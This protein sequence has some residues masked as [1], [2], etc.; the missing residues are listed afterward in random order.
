MKRLIASLTATIMLVGLLAACGGTSTTTPGATVTDPPPS[1]SESK[2]AGGE[3]TKPA[4][5]EGSESA[6]VVDPGGSDLKLVDEPVEVRIATQQATYFGEVSEL[7]FTKWYAEKTGV[8]VKWETVPQASVSETVSLMMA[9]PDSLPDAM[10][11]LD[12][13]TSDLVRYGSQ[14]IF[15]PLQDYIAEKGKYTKAAY[16][17]QYLKEKTAPDG[18]IYALPGVNACYHCMYAG[19]AYI[20]QTW[21][22]NLGLEYPNTTDEFYEVLKAFKEQDANNNGDPND[23]IPMFGASTGWNTKV[24]DH[25]MGAFVYNDHGRRLAL[26]DGKITFVANTEAWKQGL[27][28]I[29]K[30]FDEEFI[31]ATALTV[32]NDGYTAVGGDIN[33]IRVGVVTGATWWSGLGN[34]ASAPLQ[35]S[36]QYVGLSPLEGPEGE[37]NTLTIPSPSATA[38]TS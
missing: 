25:L 27:L 21:L 14:G 36:R 17:D 23:E 28:Y 35:R 32:D 4:D 16:T 8:T 12:F 26:E 37:R 1:A 24:Y 15:V 9:N 13:S 10:M 3:T 38:S 34:D 2:D 33:S 6:P 7:T 11:G 22:D 19:K 5:P 20:N 31:D 29:R 18:N 30:L